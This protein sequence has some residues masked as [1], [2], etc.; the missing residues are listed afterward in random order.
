MAGNYIVLET[1]YVKKD[2]IIGSSYEVGA[3]V[4]Y[5]GREMIV[6]QAPDGDGEIRMLDYSGLWAI[7]AVLPVMKELK[8]LK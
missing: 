5:E 8:E 4:T 1:G 3:K 2:K 6:N 7:C